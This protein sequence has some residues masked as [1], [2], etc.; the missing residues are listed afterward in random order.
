M[1]YDVVW[2]KLS[3]IDV[4]NKTEKKGNLTYLSWAWAW[5]ELMKHFPMAVVEFTEWDYPD[6]TQ[7]DILIYPDGTCS[8]ECTLTIEDISRKM[9]LP[10]MDYKNDAIPDPNARQI[11]DAK[12]R[13]LV[14]CISMF[15][16]GHYIYAGEDLPQETSPPATKETA[17]KKTAEKPKRKLTGA[18]ME[19][20]EIIRETVTKHPVF[21]NGGGLDLCKQ[22]LSVIDGDPTP[23][24]INEWHAYVV[25]EASIHDNKKQDEEYHG[26]Q[27][28]D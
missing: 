19:Q 7:K 26:R 4:S 23:A 2:N 21:T 17:P 11:S 9:W 8:V 5:G 12:M 15:G 25:G 1:K 16:L 13:C 27:N 22:V 20:V 3:E 18:Q 10:V 28:T 24:Q 6:A 14:K